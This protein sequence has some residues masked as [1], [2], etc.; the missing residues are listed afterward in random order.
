MNVTVYVPKSIESLLKA[1]AEQ[2]RITPARFV[3]RLIKRELEADEP[4]FSEGFIALAG[5]WED[6]RSPQEIIQDIDNNRVDS[7]RQDL[8]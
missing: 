3:Q 1:A 4:S 8:A 6:N 7:R 2:A 5:S